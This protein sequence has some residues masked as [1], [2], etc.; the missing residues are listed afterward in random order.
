MG[1]SS[2]RKATRPLLCRNIEGGSKAFYKLG[3][4]SEPRKESQLVAGVLRLSIVGLRDYK[5]FFIIGLVKVIVIIFGQSGIGTRR[6]SLIFT[7]DLLDFKKFMH[8]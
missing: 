4:F 8:N 1:F 7:L 6:V 2:L 5:S 3:A